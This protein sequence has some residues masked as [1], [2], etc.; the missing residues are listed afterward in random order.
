MANI[1]VYDLSKE[2]GVSNKEVME[3]AVKI[4][5][6][7]KSHSSSISDEEARRIKDNLG[8]LRSNGGLA[9]GG[10]GLDN[11]AS[12]TEEQIRIIRSETEGEEIVERRKG[13]SVVLRKRR[14]KVVE[15]KEEPKPEETNFEESQELTAAGEAAE[16]AEVKQT[17]LQD[18]PQVDGAP[19]AETLETHAEE[20]SPE[21]EETAAAPEA[22]DEGTLPPEDGGLPRA[23]R[24]AEAKGR[25]QGAEAQ[26]NEEARKKKAKKA[27]KP[28]RGEIIDEETLKE[29][30]RAFKTKLP[31]KKR[32]FLVDDKKPRFR[33]A[34]NG[35]R[36]GRQTR[37]TA[38][39][40][41]YGAHSGDAETARI[42][43]FPERHVK[44]PIKLGESVN[45]GELAKRMGIKSSG[46]I[47]KLISLGVPATINQSIDHE[48]ATIVAEELGYEVT[49]DL[50]E[51]EDLLLEKDSEVEGQELPRPPV[52]TVMGHVDHG[53]TTLLDS[54]RRT[55]VVD[56]E[57]GGITQHI[58]AYCVDVRE[59][60]VVFIDTPGHEAFTAMRSR[61][62]QVTDIVILVVAADDGV[63]PQTEEAVNHS[64]AAEVPII[65]ALNKIDKPDADKDKV[66][67]E[68]S[69]IG[70]VS[71]EWGGETMVCEVSAKT[72]H[73]IDGLLEMVLLQADML[74]LTA[75]PNKRAN[76]TVI[77]AKLDRGKGPVATVIVK[78]GTLRV[79]N[80][81]LAGTT[82]G[83]VRALVDDKGGRIDEATPSLPVEIVGLSGVPS[84]GNN[85]YVVKNEKTAKEIVAHRQGRERE[86]VAS[87]SVKLSLENLFDTLKEGEIKELLLIIKTD[88]QGSIE[89]LKDSIENIVSEKCRVKIIHSAVGAINETDIA[90]GSASNAIVIGFNVRPEPKALEAAEREN[91][92]VEL[93][94]VIYDVLDRIKSAMVG[95]LEPIQSERILGHADVKATFRVSKVGTIAGCN[96]S[97][98]LVSR[99]DFVRVIRDGVTVYEGR[100]GS[101]KRF[102]DDVREVQS[103]YECGIG[104]ESFN[105][106]KVGDRFELFTYDEVTPEL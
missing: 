68:L 77:D 35:G 103:G 20:L 34:Q 61:G 10:E 88:V 102:K 7:V 56:K 98:G 54:I 96:V 16:P 81:V 37:G 99:N 69:E 51:E 31:V 90:L 45:V 2:L 47:K 38:R 30:R 101:L 18:R 64:K 71:E 23:E 76:G 89:A 48:T 49:P 32:E 53:K 91:V 59:N 12:D 39:A 52:V 58:G 43:E 36:S 82:Y 8:S 33:G 73:G 72:G 41:Q 75:N 100:L 25:R 55:N 21:A 87:T 29:L 24:G 28:K 19:T 85:F 22:V 1:R 50:F 105:D 14:K 92:S 97:D 57:A 40:E 84:G 106:I 5:I 11:K 66:L 42:I 93:H 94:S 74:E 9:P 65:V 83:K 80:V 95:L 26:R 62:A 27:V 60:R 104:I 78:D 6:R 63:M 3:L 70:L 17:P 13:H 15:P 46:L 44:R 86:M 67:R 79:G 4:G